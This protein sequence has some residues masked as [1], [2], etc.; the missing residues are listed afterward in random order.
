MPQTYVEGQRLKGSDG[1]TYVVVNGTPMLESS[2]RNS[3]VVKGGDPNK[4]EEDRIN[5]DIKRAQLKKIQGDLPP[6]EAPI[7]PNGATGQDFLKT[8][9]PADQAIVKGLANGTIAFPTG[10]ALRTPYWQRMLGNVVNFDPDFDQVNYG[11]RY[12]TRKDFTSG[13]SSQNIKALNT[14]IGHLGQLYSQIGGTSSTN[15][16]PYNSVA[17]ATSKIFGSSGPTLYDQTA[18]AVSSELTQVFRGSGGAE[19]D[20]QRYLGELNSNASL[21]QKQAAIRN[22]MGLLNSRLEAVRD[23][24]AKGM[25]T[26]AQP[27][28]VLDPHAKEV[29]SAVMGEG[30]PPGLPQVDIT[31]LGGTPAAPGAKTLLAEDT[32][33]IP[34]PEAQKYFSDINSLAMAG[35]PDEQFLALAKERGVAPPTAFLNWRRAN[36][37][38][39]RGPLTSRDPLTKEVPNDSTLSNVTG[40]VNNEAIGTFAAN[41]G[42]EVALG[43]PQIAASALSG[44]DARADAAWTIMNQNHPYAAGAGKLVGSAAGA[45]AA[46]LSA[47]RAVNALRLAKG[48]EPLGDV[49]SFLTRRAADSGSGAVSGY[50]SAADGQ[51]LNGAVMGAIAA[52]LTGAVGEGLGRFAV[53]PPMR[54]PDGSILGGPDK[55]PQSERMITGAM[56]NPGKVVDSL[57]EGR[58]LGLP[59]TAADTDPGLRS[60]AGSAVRRSPTA[61]GIAEDTLIPRGRGQIDRFQGG[62]NKNLGPT[63]NVPQLTDDM[64]AGAKAKAGPL[65]DKAYGAPAVTSDKITDIL[66]TPFGQKA[67]AQAV[68]IAKNE[69]VNPNALSVDFNAAGEPVMR[70]RPSMRTLDL[71]KRGMDDVLEGYRDTTTGRLN[72]GESGQ[73]ELGVKRD[74]LSELDRLNPAYKKARAAYSG[75]AQELDVIRK[76][77]DAF[78]APPDALSFDVSKMAPAKR[79]LLQL[80]Y[81]DALSKAGDNYRLSSNPYDMTLGTPAAESRLLS[82]YGADEGAGNLLRLRDIERNMQST[83]NDILG[84]SK[85]A[86]RNIA[87]K[88]FAGGEVSNA[89]ADVALSTVLGQPPVGTMV[90]AV[91][92]GLFDKFKMGLGKKGAANADEIARVLLKADPDATLGDLAD[93]VKRGGDYKAY[94]AGRKKKYGI[95]GGIAGAYVGGAITDKVTNN[96]SRSQLAAP[97]S[98]GL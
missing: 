66:N 69:R 86:Q 10:A 89:V 19:A 41:A 73:A 24:Y 75:P 96:P 48:L 59:L 31:T 49:G 14:A 28:E 93:I 15:F 90:R 88:A 62:I 82:V 7:V 20:V 92:G 94:I 58:D 84:N 56:D 80:G 35:A 68:T 40:A 46:E 87:D 51:G 11:A 33:S 78:K 57:T 85:T 50:S 47:L 3:I 21:E 5:L 91:R 42:N 8:L 55:P 70:A 9:K 36:N 61:S 29:V 43:V 18:G 1:K 77:Q 2:V 53:E 39:W 97:Y 27:L 54:L 30:K 26:T 64:L 71:V 60:L 23:Q 74:F 6:D 13:K 95:G 37:P 52:P 79:P 63:G 4:A 76:G 22:I 72:L 17:N 67:L 83:S 16:T 25:G 45:A 38:N 44:N 65:Y 98:G 32:K 12:A 34:D 81:R